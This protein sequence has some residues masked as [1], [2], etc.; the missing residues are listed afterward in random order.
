MQDEKIVELYWNRDES[1][2]VETQQKYGRYLTKIA[3]NILTDMEDSLEC[4]NDTYM[5][6]WK[7]IPPN[8]P[9]VLSLYLAKITRRVSID[10]VRKKKRE[11]R[12]PSEYVFSLS[13]LADCISEGNTTESELEVTM[14][15]NAI[16][17]Y[18]RT[19]SKEA[20]NLF[21][22]RYYFL[23]PLKEVAKYCG[24]SESK[25]KTILYRTR[26]GLKVYLEKEGFY[27]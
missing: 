21:I 7:S 10:I 27:L 6:A 18:L 25:A 9:N 17:A 8:K 23:D 26:R 14:L 19:I 11:K 15:A 5:D 24:M 1:A 4:V 13:E 2:I 22:G 3:Y 20:R 12:L 16:N